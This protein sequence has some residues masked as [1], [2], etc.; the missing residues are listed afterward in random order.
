MKTLLECWIIRKS[1]A[2]SKL[3]QVKHLRLKLLS[4]FIIIFLIFGT[5]AED[6]GSQ[7]VET[8]SRLLD[9]RGTDETPETYQDIRKQTE[10]ES[11]R[12]GG[13][14][15]KDNQKKWDV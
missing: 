4:L 5:F 2:R 15:S 14:Y 1:K 7:H 11:Y 8:S 13:Y 3:T 9:Q 12:T 6:H 10:A